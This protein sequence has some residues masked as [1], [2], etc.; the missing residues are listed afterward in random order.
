MRLI[1][2]YLSPIL[3]LVGV[4]KPV[5]VSAING[6]LALWNCMWCLC[7]PTSADTSQWSSQ[8]RLLNT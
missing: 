1:I 6:C 8:L 7:S 3:K 5:E 4:T 2:S